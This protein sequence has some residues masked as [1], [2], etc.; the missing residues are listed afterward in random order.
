MKLYIQCPTGISGDMFLAAMGDLGLDVSQLSDIFREAGI[1]VDIY[2]KRIREK[3]LVASRLF[4]ESRSSQPLRHLSDL[5]GIIHNCP[6]SEYVKTSSDQALQKLGA[7]EAEVHGVD[8][9]DVHFHEIGA[10]DTLVD[11]VGA[12]WALEKMQ[13]TGVTCS[14]LPWFGGY[15]EC[16]HGTLPLPAPATL[17]LLHNKPVYSTEFRDELITPTG[18]LLLDSIVDS[19]APGPAGVLEKSAMGWGSKD[20]GSVPNA[21]RLFLYSGSREETENIWVLESNIDHLTGEEVGN[22]FQELLDAGALDVF[23]L[24]GIMKKNRPGGLLQVISD[25]SSLGQVQ[26][27]MFKQTLSLGIRRREMER[28][29]LPREEKEF[30]TPWGSVRGKQIHFKEQGISKPEFEALKEFAAS[31]GLSLVQMRYLLQQYGNAND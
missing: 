23:Y 6:V 13:I 5:Q 19:F 15:V 27:S 9:N 22:L 26:E 20:L 29:T 3:G 16:D 2:T 12:F 1:E 14:R 7:A 8:L 4:I 21:L 30:S 11:V 25:S 17:R 10:V 28:V 18:V 24:P 31:R